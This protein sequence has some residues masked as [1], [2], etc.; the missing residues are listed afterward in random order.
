MIIKKLKMSNFLKTVT[1]TVKHWYIPLILG[2][3][4]VAFGIYIFTV[5]IESYIALSILFAVSFVVA[6]ILEIV[7]SIQNS[8]S[9]EGWG[10]YLAGG[11]LDLG[12]GI[13][14]SIYP[15]LSMATLPFFVGFV[16][17]FKSIQAIGFAYD[18]KNYG[19]LNWGNLAIS[20]VLGLICS[21]ILIAYPVFSGVSIVV[22][23]A[24]SVI[25]AGIGLISLAFSIKKIKDYPD[26]ISEELKRR[27]EELK[28]DYYS[29]INK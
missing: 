20:G 18:M 21:F 10:W 26:K 22:F 29:E 3:L 2:I 1:N 17:M 6:G 8:K 13:I 4:F 9:L 15:G 19:L 23:T 27:I 12:V 24:L 28:K 25:F 14:L 5:P 7:F 11:I 16:V